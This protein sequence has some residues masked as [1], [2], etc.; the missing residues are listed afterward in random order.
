VAQQLW[1]KKVS[2]LVAAKLRLARSQ[3][4]RS[5]RRI[6]TE[7]EREFVNR[8]S[9]NSGDLQLDEA[10]VVFIG[11]APPRREIVSTPI[12]A[13][14]TEA[15]SYRQSVARRLSRQ[16]D[17]WADQVY[18]TCLVVLDEEHI[19]QTPLAKCTCIYDVLLPEIRGERKFYSTAI[20]HAEK[21]A[22]KFDLF[23]YGDDLLYIYRR[24]R[25]DVEQAAHDLIKRWRDKGDQYAGIGTPNTAAELSEPQQQSHAVKQASALPMEAKSKRGPK[26]NMKFHRAV[27]EVMRLFGPNW[28]EQL[29]RIAEEMDK[30]KIPALPRWAKKHPAARTWTRAAQRYPELVRKALAYSLKMVEKDT[31]RK[32]SQT[33]ANSR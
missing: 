11:S 24:E 5:I 31:T 21:C 23:W 1:S 8:P 29:E 9:G 25:E 30:K 19:A 10:Q 33:L 12:V 27:V 26:A 14:G 6:L 16:L 13:A 17:E 28:T 7:A 2:N 15:T 3:I 4:H 32:P 20:R 18:D 22:G